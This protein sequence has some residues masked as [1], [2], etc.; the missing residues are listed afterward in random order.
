MNAQQKDD[1][2]SKFLAKIEAIK[3]GETL[4]DEGYTSLELE[5]PEDRARAFR[6][7]VDAQEAERKA[8]ADA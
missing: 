1:E 5:S 2:R 8:V 7:K 3:S 4:V 6:R